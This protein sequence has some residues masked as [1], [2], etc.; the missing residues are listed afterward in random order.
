MYAQDKP[1]NDPKVS[2]DKQHT[3]LVFLSVI[4]S[5]PAS[6]RILVVYACVYVRVCACVCVVGVCLDDWGYFHF[7]NFS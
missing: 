6:A 5:H 1:N 4:V 7:N 2:C 3:Y